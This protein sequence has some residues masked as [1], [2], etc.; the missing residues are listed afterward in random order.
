MINQKQKSIVVFNPI[1]GYGHLDSWSLLFVRIFL[2]LGW[3]VDVISADITSLERELSTDGLI[4]SRFLS[5]H[6][7]P[8][9]TD[10]K[11]IIGG[12]HLDFKT[13]YLI[14]KNTT[15]GHKSLGHISQYKKRIRFLYGF[16]IYFTKHYFFANIK[17]YLKLFYKNKSSYNCFHDV[18]NMIKT[19]HINPD[20]IF[21]MYLD[22]LNFKISKK[23]SLELKGSKKWAGLRFAPCQDDLMFYDGH[24]EI[25]GV[26]FLDDSWKAYFDARDKDVIFTTLPDVAS[27]VLKSRRSEIALQILA[28]AN[29]RKIVFLG[30]MIGWTK[31]ID[32]WYKL[33][34]LADPKKWFFLQVGKIIPTGMSAADLY[35]IYAATHTNKENLMI[36]PT[37][38]EDE[39]SFN[40]LISI[41]DIIYAVYRNFPNSSNMLTKAAG[42]FKPIIVSSGHLMAQRVEK[43]GI[44]RIVDERDSNLIYKIIEEMP[45][46]IHFSKNFNKYNHDFN[47]AALKNKL[48]TFLNSLSQ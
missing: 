5:I 3:K 4:N 39:S 14:E 1:S 15:V 41:S 25:K 9:L 36:I 24:P 17:K 6:K 47:E 20:L 29:D 38:L 42:F 31:N 40:E 34:K 37:Y 22:A 45:D 18:E 33:V 30:G 26:C 13:Y 28:R 21:H 44:G 16:A 46:P 19:L 10:K 7:H 35:S 11:N 12:A 43:Y 32:T 48:S 23:P 27:S 2:Q 8:D